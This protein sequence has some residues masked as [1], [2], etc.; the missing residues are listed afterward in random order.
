MT[1]H[2]VIPVVLSRLKF[3][4]LS[5]KVSQYLTF[6]RRISGAVNETGVQFA[7]AAIYTSFSALASAL[8]CRWVS[9]CWDFLEST[10][11]RTPLIKSS[12]KWTQILFNIS[13]S[14]LGI[15]LCSHPRIYL[16][17]QSNLKIKNKASSF[18][19]LWDF[20]AII[21]IISFPLHHS[22]TT[23][24]CHDNT[25]AKFRISNVSVR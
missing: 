25:C 11:A 3:I 22:L 5:T 21:R 15:W 18:T 23:S 17:S 12:Q 8:F 13:N 19:R 1:L 16:N 24:H 6:I 20:H 10:Q 7:C 2:G 14:K 4:A 9:L